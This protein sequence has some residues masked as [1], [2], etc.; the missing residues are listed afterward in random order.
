MA[1]ETHSANFQSRHAGPNTIDA[2]ILPEEFTSSRMAGCTSGRREVR[3]NRPMRVL[4]GTQVYHGFGP[5][6]RSRD[7]FE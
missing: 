6:T 3:D 2:P 5:R 1:R 4:P 7:S